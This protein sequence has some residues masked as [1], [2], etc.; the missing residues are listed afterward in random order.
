MGAPAFWHEAQQVL[1]CTD[2]Q[3]Y[4]S[5]DVPVLP[6]TPNER[7]F[8]LYMLRRLL[9]SVRVEVCVIVLVETCSSVSLTLSFHSAG[10]AR[11]RRK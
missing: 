8:C 9:N 1:T 7:M 6:V 2:C 3:I 5:R 10:R 11:S 4:T